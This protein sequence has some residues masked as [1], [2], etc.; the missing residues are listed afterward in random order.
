MTGWAC[1]PCRPLR[2][3]QESRTFSRAV[4]VAAAGI[5]DDRVAVAQLFEDRAVPDSAPVHEVLL[6]VL[7]LNKPEA[8]IRDHP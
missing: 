4:P 2:P 5:E 3:S 6:T 8:L 7:A 1:V